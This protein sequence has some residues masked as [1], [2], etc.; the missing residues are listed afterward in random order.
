MGYILHILHGVDEIV[1]A[2][3]RRAGSRPT[4]HQLGRPKPEAIVEDRR[5]QFGLVKC[6]RDAGDGE[7]IRLMGEELLVSLIPFVN[8]P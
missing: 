8:V 2:Q 7:M 4:R 6:A 5:V 3:R 1:R